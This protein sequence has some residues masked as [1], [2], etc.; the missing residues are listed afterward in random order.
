MGDLDSQILHVDLIRAKDLIKADIIGK[1]DPYAVLKYADQKDKTGVVKN[2]QNPKW[3]HAA[4][5]SMR[6]NETAQLM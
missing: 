1:S 2:T 5:F 6:P 3:D 4:D